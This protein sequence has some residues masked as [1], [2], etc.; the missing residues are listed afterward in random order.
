MRCRNWVGTC[1]NFGDRHIDR[2]K[3]CVANGTMKYAIIGSEGKGEN[4]TPHLQ[5]TFVFKN[6]RQLNGI[7]EMLGKKWHLEPCAN[8]M[9]SIEYCKKEGDFLELGEAPLNQEQKGQRSKTDWGLVLDKAKRGDWDGIDPKIQLTCYRAIE[10]HQMRT[11]RSSEL[12]DTLETMEWHY[13]ATGLGKSR[14]ARFHNPNILDKPFNKWWDGWASDPRRP[15][16][17]EDLD[18]CCCE[19]LAH[20]FKIW[21]DRYSFS[22]EVKGGTI[23][24]RPS[25]VVC[26]SNYSLQDCF[27]C[28]RDLFAL[29]RRFRCYKYYRAEDG[30]VYIEV[31][32]PMTS[33]GVTPPSYVSKAPTFNHPEVTS[34]PSTPMQQPKFSECPELK[35]SKKYKSDTTFID[36]T[37]RDDDETSTLPLSTAERQEEEEECDGETLGS[38]DTPDNGELDASSDDDDDSSSSE[39]DG[40]CEQ[41]VNQLANI[42]EE[43]GKMIKDHNN[44]LV[45]AKDGRESRLDK[46]KEEPRIIYKTAQEFNEQRKKQG[47]PLVDD[48]VIGAERFHTGANLFFKTRGKRPPVEDEEEI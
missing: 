10:F 5:C 40:Y 46:P 27:P 38:Q 29:Q 23:R 8:V 14:G 7:K 43:H 22:A 31:T 36:L 19:R 18:P 15:V 44:K 3:E 39:D 9:K 20:Y 35:N 6:A 2:V 12:P 37:Q 32:E 26:T 25:K 33:G 1:N 21:S 4:K 41:L 47:L 48:D 17:F 13:G 11:I 30:E 16:L 24:C 45:N 28:E 42:R 34:V